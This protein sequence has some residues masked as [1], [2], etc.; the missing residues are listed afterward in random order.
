MSKYDPLSDRLAGHPASEWRANFAELEEVLGFPLPK[1]A[2]T[3]R[4]CQGT[5]QPALVDAVDQVAHAHA[6]AFRRHKG[7]PHLEPTRAAPSL[8]I[9][10][11]EEDP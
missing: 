3:G 7:Y 10:A 4:T 5:R 9:D 8:T 2:R 6:A 1:A 11:L